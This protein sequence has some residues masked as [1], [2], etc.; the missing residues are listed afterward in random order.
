MQFGVSIIPA[1]YA[2]N[3]AELGR[4][5]EESGFESLFLPEHIHIPVSRRTP[6]FGGAPLPDG[7]K[8]GLDPFLALT[9]VALTTRRL[10]LGTGICLVVQRDP[11]TLAKEVATLDFLSDGRFLFGV[12]GGWNLEEMENHGTKPPLRW[13]VL[14]ERILAMK[15]IWTEDEAEFHGELV[16]FDPIWSWPKPVQRPHPPVLVGG[17]GPRTLQRVVEYSDG[18]MPGAAREDGLAERIDELQRLARAAGRG[19][20]PVTAWTVP[21]DPGLIERY[22]TLGIARCVFR[23]PT[24][25]ADEVLPL[26]AKLGA[27]TQRYT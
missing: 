25:D 12:G 23:L 24:A 9:A 17:N 18:W 7:Y 16:N 4:A 1:H 8:H 11:I 27:L 21:P 13:K 22:Q 10:R 19:P 26:L 15:R 20:I 3:V 6:F 14:R 2:I 5:A